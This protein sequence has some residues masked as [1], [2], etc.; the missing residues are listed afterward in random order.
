MTDVLTQYL[1]SILKANQYINLT[2]ITDIEQ[3]RLL[4]IEDSLAALPEME[5]APNGLYGDMGSGGGFPGVPLALTTNRQT[6]LID[7][8][9]KKM[10]AVQNILHE[11][12]IDTLITTEG[13]RIEELSQDYCEQFAVITA[14]ALSKLPSL[15]ELASPLLQQGGHLICLKAQL[16][17]EELEQALQIQDKTAL[18]L[19]SRRSYVLS[20]NKTYREIIVFKKE[21]EPTIK[22][23]RRTGMAQK[24][25][26]K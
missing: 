14:R 17:D 23:P 18:I 19:Y 2:T 20:D 4:H 1:D 12:N 22:L 9:K 21:G 13:R 5:K 10:A 8:V 3:A 26:L 24:R 7:S 16:E 11:L 25:P 6:I 15:M